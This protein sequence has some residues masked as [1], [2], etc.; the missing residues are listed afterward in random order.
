[1]GVFVEFVALVAI[2]V[3]SAVFA[4]ACCVG[5]SAFGVAAS[6]VER[7]RFQIVA[8]AAAIRITIFTFTR[9]CIGVTFLM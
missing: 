3:A 7:I 9:E 6:A 2:V 8:Q 5:H 4:G 1:M